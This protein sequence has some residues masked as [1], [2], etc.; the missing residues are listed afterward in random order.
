MIS[1]ATSLIPFLEQI[2]HMIMIRV[3]SFK[4]FPKLPYTFYRK[5]LLVFYRKK[6]KELYK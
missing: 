2:D 6:I 1:V 3:F 4:K 5:I